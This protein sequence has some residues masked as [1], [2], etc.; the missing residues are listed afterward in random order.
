MGYL[1]VSIVILSQTV[2]ES[3]LDSSIIRR[4]CNEGNLAP[5]ALTRRQVVGKVIHGVSWALRQ[6]TALGLGLGVDK[7]LAEAIPVG[8]FRGILDYDLLVVIGELVDDVLDALSELEL[9][10]LGD[11]LLRDLDTALMSRQR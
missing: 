8:V 4:P 9:V 7:L 5:R 11:A 1:G 3:Y 6:R 10:E 2:S